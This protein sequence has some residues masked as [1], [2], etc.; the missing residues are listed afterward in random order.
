VH[1]SIILDG[2]RSRLD[3]LLQHYSYRNL[4]SYI[5]KLNVYSEMSARDMINDGRSYNFCK[6]LFYPPAAFIKMY[7]QKAGFLD[8]YHGLL[9]AALSSFHVFVKY[10]KFRELYKAKR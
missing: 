7:I 3:G 6:L 10:A 8:G 2:N 4:D 9:L 5:E 1:E